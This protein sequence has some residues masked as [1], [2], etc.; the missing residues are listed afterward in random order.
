[1]N[2]NEFM[3]N[4]E[5]ITG[6]KNFTISDDDY[7]AIEL[8]YAFHPA[9]SEMRGKEQIAWIYVTLGMTVIN[10]MKP[11]AIRAR[12]LEGRIAQAKATYNNTMAE[13]ERFKNV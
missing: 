2:Q 7:K 5:L 13:Y 8:V 11:R 6:A 4:C 9:I 3:H 10:D 12:E 1:M